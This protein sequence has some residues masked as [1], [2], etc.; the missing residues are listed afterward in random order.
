MSEQRL[1]L[2][3]GGR[4]AVVLA[5]LLGAL[6]LAGRFLSTF[7]VE[8]LWFDTVGYSS[9]FWTRT[10]WRW[11]ARLVAGLGVAC[12]I[13]LNLR[14]VA[15]T[16]GSIQIKRRFGNLEISEQLPRSYVMWGILAISALLGLW[17]GALVPSGAGLRLLLFFQS[18]AWGQVDPILQKDLSYYAFVLPVLAAGVTMILVLLFLTVALSVAGYAATG[19]LRWDEGR[20]GVSDVPRIHLAGLVAAFLLL[21]AFRF[22]LSRDLL[23][24]DGNSGVQGI[25]GYADDQARLPGMV[26]LTAVTVAAAGAVAWG[27]LRSRF[28][29]GV[30]GLVAVILTALAAGELVPSLNQ[31]FRVEPNELAR[32]SPYIRHNMAFTRIGFGLTEI[33]RRPFEYSPPDDVDW[34]EAAR[35]FAGLP[36]W[37]RNTLLTTYREL[38][39]RFRYYDFADVAIDRYAAPAGVEPTALSVREVDPQG[40]PDPNWQNLHLRERYITGQG[41]VA[42]A[43]ARQSEEGRARMILSGIPPEFQAAEWAPPSLILNQPTVYFGARPQLYA[44][45]NPSDTTFRAPDGS[46]GEVGVDFPRGI[47]LSSGLRLLALAWRFREANL[48]FATEVTDSSRFVFRRSVVERV[49]TIAPFFDYLEAPYPVVVDGRIQWILEGF[50]ATRWFP[51]SSVRTLQGS[52]RVSYVRNSVKA[53]VDAVTGEVRF[54][55]MDDD[56]PLLEAYRAAF[57]DLV[58]PLAEMPAGIRSHLRYPRSLLDVQTTVLSQYHQ[59][60]PEIF[61]GQRDVW[62]LAREQGQNTAAVPYRPSYGHYRIPGADEASF[63]LST[64]FVPQG[65]PNLTALLVAHSDPERYGQLM[66]FDIPVADQVPGPRN[67][68]VLVEQDPVISQ[69]FSLWRQGGSQ[70]WSGHL[71]LVPVGSTLLYMEPIFLAAEADAIPELR[72]YVVSDGR[73]VA[74]ERSLEETIAAL[75]GRSPR[76]TEEE[77]EPSRAAATPDTARAPGAGEQWPAEALEV[78]READQRLRDGDWEGF[79]EA[80][81]RLE[82]LLERIAGSDTISG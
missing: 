18:P 72:R 3:K 46:R 71:H 52:R 21:L 34:E 80:L 32:E 78:L 63:V 41:A 53:T 56:D 26:I 8:V 16:L 45:V 69:Q 54:Y 25:F 40:I 20:V 36:V 31:R 27:G 67:V 73:R 22:W 9:V 6:L 11:G 58:R 13:Y 77:A 76:E 12:L 61:H 7:Y 55:A 43:A 51:L 35:Q 17:V 75:S 66:L 42:S 62:E 10:L 50:T 37:D 79:G 29:P 65:R 60:T 59:E 15:A 1:R 81:D 4:P 33:E 38:E 24:L 49:Q 57:P 23:L 5:V 14:I 28:I 2:P 48:L 82:S 39:A 74:M 44:V 70:V 68:E 64:V 30:A 19:A 47:R